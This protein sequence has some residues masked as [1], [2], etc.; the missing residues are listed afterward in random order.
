MSSGFVPA[1]AVL[2]DPEDSTRMRLLY[3]SR[4]RNDLLFKEE[5]EAAAAG[6]AWGQATR[7]LHACGR[8]C[9]RWLAC[10]WAAV[11]HQAGAAPAQYVASM[12]LLAHRSTPAGCSW[13]TPL[14][15][16]LRRGGHMRGAASRGRWCR[17]AGIHRGGVVQ[18]KRPDIGPP[19]PAC[20][21]YCYCW[22]SCCDIITQQLLQSSLPPRQPVRAEPRCW[23][24]TTCSQA[25]TYVAGRGTLTLVC[26]PP[27]FK[28]AA[29]QALAAIGHLDDHIVVF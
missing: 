20:R 29:L 1:Q 4:G 5:L 25:H 18:P 12:P 14:A 8:Q 11:V 6:G 3:S 28:E 15:G 17:W 23:W 2:L 24:A 27:P 19:G 7:V 10:L 16:R 21:C 22:Y 26:G 13:S 9:S